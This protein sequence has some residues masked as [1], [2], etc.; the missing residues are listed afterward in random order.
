MQRT[1]YKTLLRILIGALAYAFVL[2]RLWRADWAAFSLVLEQRGALAAIGLLLV[3]LMMLA[4]WAVE[5]QKWRWATAHFM[6]LTFGQCWRT[7]W[8]GV[9]VGMLSPNRVGEPLG[10]LAQTPAEHRPRALAASVWCALTQ[11]FATLF[12][13][14][15]ALL[16]WSTITSETAQLGVKVAVP[17]VFAAVWMIAI[18][19]ALVRYDSLMRWLAK[20]RWLQRW[21]PS[22]GL[23][24]TVARPVAM[25][26]V[27]GSMFKY[28]IFSTQYVVLLRIFG[29]DAPW[30]QL[31]T[32][33]AVS[34][35]FVTFVP[36]VAATEL[37]VRMGAAMLFLGSITSNQGGVAVAS[38]TLW[39]VNIGIPALA[40]V[41][42]RRRG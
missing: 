29:V 4:V 24:W 21:L 27:A 38:F 25:R 33:V 15:V 31:Y 26:I 37:V 11:Q 13:G 17:L 35:L 41:W 23:V 1:S 18:V 30:L 3:L 42:M 36:S 32:G 12:F 6:P 28:L 14:A 19:V 34:Y 22:D 40:G 16:F 5:A 39:M 9:V 7:V 8:Y 10:R 20:R 2:Y